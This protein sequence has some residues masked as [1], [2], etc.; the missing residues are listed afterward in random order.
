MKKGERKIKDKIGEAHVKPLDLDSKKKNQMSKFR[1]KPY[2]DPDR[3][4]WNRRMN[5]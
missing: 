2:Q 3:I 1:I 4:F 5:L